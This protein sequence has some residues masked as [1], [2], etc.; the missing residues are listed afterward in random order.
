MEKEIAQFIV[1]LLAPCAIIA[2]LYSIWNHKPKVSTKYT[3]IINEHTAYKNR[4][5]NR[6]SKDV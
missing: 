5:Y 1:Y 2:V 4:Q 3:D 6:R